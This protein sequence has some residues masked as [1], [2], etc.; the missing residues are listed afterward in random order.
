MYDTEHYDEA[1][2]AA[3]RVIE[4]TLRQALGRSDAT[5]KE[6]LH[7]GLNVATGTLQDPKAWQSEREGM[8]LLFKAA[9]QS[10][11]DRRA[12]G[13]VATEAEEAF[14]LIVLANRMLLIA[15]ERDR[16]SQHEPTTSYVVDTDKLLSLLGAQRGHRAQPVLLDADGDGEPELLGPGRME[17]GEVLR[18][19]KVEGESAKQVEVER[20]DPDTI[21]A[22]MN[23]SAADVDNDGRQEVVCTVSA[24]NQPWALMFYKFR[25]G[26]YEILRT[27]PRH[28]E[29]FSG[30]QTVWLRAHIADIN[31]DG[32]L[33]VVEEPKTSGVMPP[34]VRYIWKWDED[35][36]AFQL[37][38]QEELTWDFMQGRL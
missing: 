27:V 32:E 18:I 8:Y 37:L 11:R 4:E 31:D 2:L 1:V 21:W 5:M 34:P 29:G 19:S 30:R 23:I 6:L 24:G 25:N 16:S 10:F 14:D 9:F 17:E 7:E 13:F 20:I 33:E 3:F 26:R 38:Y 35:A 12:H 15:K 28:D 22:L 36:G